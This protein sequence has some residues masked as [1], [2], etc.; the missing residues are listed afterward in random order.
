VG[1]DKPDGDAPDTAPPPMVLVEQRGGVRRLRLN[2]PERLNALSSQLLQRL[3]DELRSAMD[4][5]GTA[6]VV[7][8]GEG[9]A[10]S[11]GVDVKEAA[12][13]TTAALRYDAPKGRRVAREQ[14]DDWLALWSLPKPLIAQIQGYCLGQANELVGCCDLVVCG[15]SSQFGFPE[16]RGI[17]MFPTLGFLPDRIGIQRTKE[18]AFTGRLVGGPEAVVL[19]LALECVPDEQLEARVDELAAS[20]AEVGVDRLSVLKAAVNGWAEARGIRVAASR[21]SEFH[22]LYHQSNPRIGFADE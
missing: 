17:A 18:L 8:S 19:G 11:A 9:R 2:R 6:V 1:S 21:G 22:A 20:I 15:E 14:V 12:H 3:R 5:D 16:M 10:F 7:L 4:D 13:S